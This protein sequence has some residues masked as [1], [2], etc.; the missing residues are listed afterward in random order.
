MLQAALRSPALRLKGPVVSRW[1][2]IGRLPRAR[3]KLLPRRLASRSRGDSGSIKRPGSATWIQILWTPSSVS[4]RARPSSISRVSSSSMVTVRRWVKSSR[5]PSPGLGCPAEANRRSASASSSGLNPWSQ[6]VLR[7][8]GSWWGSHWPRSTSRWRI[9]PG[10]VS[11]RADCRAWRN[12]AGK[13]GWPSP[14]AQAIS[15]SNSERAAGARPLGSIR[16]RWARNPCHWSCNR[17]SRAWRWRSLRNLLRSSIGRA[18]IWPWRF[19]NSSW[20][21]CNHNQQDARTAGPS[22]PAT[23][24]TQSARGKA[25]PISCISTQAA[26]KS[27]GRGKADWRARPSSDHG[28]ALMLVGGGEPAGRRQSSSSSRRG[29]CWRFAASPTEMAALLPVRETRTAKRGDFPSSVPRR[30]PGWKAGEPRALL[31][32]RD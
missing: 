25:P 7:N 18:S 1:G 20:G 28:D 13:G 2:N 4:S 31:S 17:S 29:C 23:N 3:Y 15:S 26:P 12:P 14:L 6:V 11:Q 19:R 8:D 5:S 27:L 22:Q 10:S 9:A 24:S 30:S 16:W 21:P 32:L